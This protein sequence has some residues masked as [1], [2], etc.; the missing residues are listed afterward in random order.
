M[1]ISERTETSSQ[2]PAFIAYSGADT[3]YVD[4]FQVRKIVLPER[5]LE[6]ICAQ[7]EVIVA[8]KTSS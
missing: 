1:R 8:T 5:I 7:N 2:D 3:N 4:K 6:K